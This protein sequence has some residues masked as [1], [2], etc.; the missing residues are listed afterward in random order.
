MIF[1]IYFSQ[2]F[3]VSPN[4]AETKK[5]LEDTVSSLKCVYIWVYVENWVW[6]CVCS[7]V[8]WIFMQ[9]YIY[10]HISIFSNSI[11]LLACL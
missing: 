3:K 8:S 5:D 1:N 6:I 4:K 9:V 10:V 7:I 2:I 11:V